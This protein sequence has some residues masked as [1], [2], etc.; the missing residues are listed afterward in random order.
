MIAA[1]KKDFQ[2]ESS[3]PLRLALAFA[4]V[5]LG[6]RA[7]VD[8]IVLSLPSRYLGERCRR[9]LLEMGRDLLPD[10]YPYL[11]DPEP[12]VRAA[13]A[14]VMAQIGD[15]AAIERLTPLISDPSTKVADRANRA[16]ERLRNIQAIAQ[17]APTR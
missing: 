11:N 7:F 10:L 16:V 12:E 6:D 14:D 3:E 17:G 5:R 1:F 2:R 9:Y 4:L 8:T 13:L 15:P